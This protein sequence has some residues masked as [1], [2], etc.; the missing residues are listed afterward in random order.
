[1]QDC[2]YSEICFQ[3]NP[4]YWSC[5]KYIPLFC[6][7]STQ[8]EFFLCVC[9]FKT[10]IWHE[11][12]KKFFE[13]VTILLLLL[14]FNVF[15]SHKAYG[16]LAPWPGIKAAPSALESKLLTSG[17]RGN[18]SDWALVWCSPWINREGLR[19]LSGCVLATI[20]CCSLAT[21]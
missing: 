4:H 2:R 17:L 11:S 21:K 12:F 9:V 7:V 20:F 13:F 10:F 15:L 16:I 1:M 8:A 3:M 5:I 6:L 18:P 19:V 14:F